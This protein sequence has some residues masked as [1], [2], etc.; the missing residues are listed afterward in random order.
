MICRV[1]LR[2]IYRSNPK[3]RT[4]WKMI[5]VL[6]LLPEN[7]VRRCV[8]IGSVANRVSKKRGFRR[9][10]YANVGS[11]TMVRHMME[12]YVQKYWRGA[13][14]AHICSLTLK[15][16]SHSV[17]NLLTLSS[18]QFSARNYSLTTLTRWKSVLT[19][20]MKW[21]KGLVCLS[22]LTSWGIWCSYL[23][24]IGCL[25]WVS[26]GNSIQ[27]TT[28]TFSSTPWI[29]TLTRKKI[30]KSVISLNSLYLKRCGLKFTFSM[31]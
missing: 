23:T 13:L 27:Y 8:S 3:D 30:R 1:S 28:H 22:R 18:A 9:E 4:F 19:V 20:V 17:F 15:Y 21:P 14:N 10:N 7:D 16:H 29:T 26:F 12:G 25:F 24:F 2:T 11:V 31:N 5:A 6:V